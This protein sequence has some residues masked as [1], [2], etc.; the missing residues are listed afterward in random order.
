M[1]WVLSNSWK[2]GYLSIDGSRF[3]IL[4]FSSN[5]V[6]HGLGANNFCTVPAEMILDSS[7]IRSVI[8]GPPG[9]DSRVKSNDH[10]VLIYYN[11]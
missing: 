6:H 7:D 1:H 10:T 4:I 9:I 11:I 2:H 5:Y 3:H 8:L